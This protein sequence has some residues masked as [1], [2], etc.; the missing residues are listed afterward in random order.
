[1]ANFAQRI[2]KRLLPHLNF[3]G[4]KLLYGTIVSLSALIISSIYASAFLAS[5]SP[6]FA[7][8]YLATVSYE[9]IFIIYVG[10]V[11][12]GEFNRDGF[13]NILENTAM[14]LMYLPLTV[15]GLVF[16][17]IRSLTIS[18]ANSI[19]SIFKLATIPILTRA[20][21][22]AQDAIKLN[23]EKNAQLKAINSVYNECEAVIDRIHIKLGMSD[24]VHKSYKTA[25]ENFTKN[26]LDEYHIYLKKQGITSKTLLLSSEDPNFMNI[27]EE[28]YLMHTRNR[29]VTWSFSKEFA[30]QRI[31]DDTDD[32]VLGLNSQQIANLESQKPQWCCPI[33]GGLMRNPVYVVLATGEKRYFEMLN[34]EKWM[35][36]AIDN[37]D[38]LAQLPE[39]R[40]T[41][42]EIHFD[43]D[44]YAEIKHAVSVIQKQNLTQSENTF[45]DTDPRPTFNA[46]ISE[47]IDA[48][49]STIL[50]FIKEHEDPSKPTAEQQILLAEKNPHP[51][52]W[53]QIFKKWKDTHTPQLPDAET[54]CMQYKEAEAGVSI[55]E[56]LGYIENE[57]ELLP[58]YRT[59]RARRPQPTW[60]HRYD[61]RNVYSHYYAMPPPSPAG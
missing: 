14:I 21:Q 7:I 44:L 11:F 33:T 12:Y 32:F 6:I 31:I 9:L 37:P 54:E 58:V 47:L 8:Y 26:M 3:L 19:L 38:Q 25:K 51:K 40:E 59:I 29:R 22:E 18:L 48:I 56:T 50:L 15:G 52:R 10:L 20:E 27:F 49:K 23:I 39:N 53:Q 16:K 30:M 13:F 43:R 5:F 34:L 45:N 46:R 42:T 57:N 55:V 2:K 17:N 41:I 36:R 60:M 24:A 1:M 4:N 61:A 28:W 35:N